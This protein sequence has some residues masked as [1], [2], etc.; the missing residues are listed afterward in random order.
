MSAT[1]LARPTPPVTPTT[2]ASGRRRAAL[3]LALRL[4]LRELR[5]HPLLATGALLCPALGNIC[6]GYLPPLVVAALV[7]ALA[8]RRP[9]LTVQLVTPHLFAFAGALLAGELLWRLGIHC[10]NRTD[11]YGI[12]RLSSAAWTSCWPRT[13]PSSTRT[14][15]AR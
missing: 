11:A 4:Y 14:S 7:G 6:L 3:L 13:R 15:R 9:R 5:S 10:L 2:A 1:T 8:D 12:E